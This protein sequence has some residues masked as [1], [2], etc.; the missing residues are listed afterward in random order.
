MAKDES[1][2]EF[3]FEKDE[4]VL[5]YHGPFIYEAKVFTVEIKAHASLNDFSNI[6]WQPE[7]KIDFKTRN[8]RG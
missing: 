1:D 3:N 8:K 6:T 7:K 4:R 5:C 2:L